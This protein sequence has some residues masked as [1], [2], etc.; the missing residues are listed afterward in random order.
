[1]TDRADNQSNIP[2]LY[3][4]RRGFELRDMRREERRDALVQVEGGCYNLAKLAKPL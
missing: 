3:L 4:F 2:A 1:M